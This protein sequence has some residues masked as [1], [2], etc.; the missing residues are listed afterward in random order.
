MIYCLQEHSAV[1]SGKIL[2]LAQQRQGS[3]ELAIVIITTKL[4]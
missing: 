2:H 4:T 3:H 1:V